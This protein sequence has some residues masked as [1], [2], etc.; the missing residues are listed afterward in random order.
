MKRM[1]HTALAVALASAVALAP[2]AYVAGPAPVTVVYAHH[3]SSH[4]SHHSSSASYYYCNG[5]DAH[6]HSNGVCPYA[7]DPYYYCN[8]HDAHTHKNGVCPYATSVSKTTVK[9]V[10]KKLNRLGYSCGTAD[11]VMGSKTKKALKKFQR[12][13]GL[14][15]DGVIGA[16]TLAALGL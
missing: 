11:G 3:S 14:T 7:D 9:K 12:D 5:H 8:G 2:A 4:S 1:K 15:A 6:T 16:K 13:N 10:Q